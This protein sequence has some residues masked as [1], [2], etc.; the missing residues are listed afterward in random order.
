MLALKCLFFLLKLLFSIALKFVSFS[1]IFLSIWFFFRTKRYFRS[2]LFCSPSR[3]YVCIF[4]FWKENISVYLLCGT[5]NVITLKWNT[6][7][8][9]WQ[10]KQSYNSGRSGEEGNKIIIDHGYLSLLHYNFL[11][12]FIPWY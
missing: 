8:N 3:Y 9:K 12:T 7:T 5:F 6:K 2:H 1:K 11:S 10:R 4:L